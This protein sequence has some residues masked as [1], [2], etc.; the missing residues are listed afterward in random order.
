MCY[1]VIPSLFEEKNLSIPCVE[2]VVCMDKYLYMFA[3]NLDHILSETY[4]KWERF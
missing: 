4:V 3:Y 2:V 1:N